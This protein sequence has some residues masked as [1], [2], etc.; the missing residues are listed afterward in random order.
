MFFRLI[1]NY[2][3]LREEGKDGQDKKKKKHY[4]H[5][6]FSPYYAVCILCMYYVN[7]L[8]SMLL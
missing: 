3:K 4:Q 8:Y 7:L 6:N 1:F 2:T 5:T